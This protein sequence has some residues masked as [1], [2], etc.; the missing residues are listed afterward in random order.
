MEKEEVKKFIQDLDKGKAK[1]ALE[2]LNFF[3]FS[4]IKPT[5][6]RSQFFV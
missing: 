6:S 3:F 4:Y 2:T 5:I 1:S